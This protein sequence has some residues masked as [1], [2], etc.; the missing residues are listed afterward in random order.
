MTPAKMRERAVVDE[1]YRER[2]LKYIS[3]L[4]T[5]TLPPNISGDYAEQFGVGNSGPAPFAHSLSLLRM[6]LRCKST[7]ISTISCCLETCTQRVTAR[8]VSS[9]AILRNVDR[10]SLDR[11]L[12]RLGWI[13]RQG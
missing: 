9:M 11:W 2:L 5:E 10:N 1:Q 13:Q 7:S 4:V 3:H 6:T 12:R 8:P